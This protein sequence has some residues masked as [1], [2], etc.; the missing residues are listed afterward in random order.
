M[1]LSGGVFNRFRLGDRDQRGP[2]DAVMQAVT[3]LQDLQH[4]VGRGIRLDGGHG[5]VFV[6]V[7]FLPCGVDLDDLEALEGVRK[8]SARVKCA[9]LAWTTL[10]NGILEYQAGR[11]ESSIDDSCAT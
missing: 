2:D 9:T 1:G 4:G 7:E 11:G 3:P 8:F 5:L 10:K 6:R